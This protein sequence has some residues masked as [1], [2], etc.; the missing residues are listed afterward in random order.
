MVYDF[1]R[2]P[3][4]PPDARARLTPREYETWQYA[5]LGMSMRQTAGA[6][7]VSI[8]TIEAHRNHILQ[9]INVGAADMTRI[10]QSA[11]K[12]L[13]RENQ[14]LRERLRVLG[15]AA[16]AACE[17]CGGTLPRNRVE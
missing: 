13:I 7:G 14:R 5:L 3:P 4:L 6:M 11:V 16:A 10:R 15:V 8:K 17:N 9:K 2:L 12:V 1:E